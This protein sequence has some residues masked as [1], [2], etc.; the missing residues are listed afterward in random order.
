[1]SDEMSLE[2]QSAENDDDMDL[3]KAFLDFGSSVPDIFETMATKETR[4]ENPDLVSEKW[5]K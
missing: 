1:M 4:D 5:V 3:D 2:I